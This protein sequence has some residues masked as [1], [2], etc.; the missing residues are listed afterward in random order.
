MAQLLEHEP[1]RRIANATV[2]TRRLEAILDEALPLADT[3]AGEG[4][5]AGVAA[6]AREPASADA[7]PALGPTQAMSAAEWIPPSLGRGPSPAGVPAELPATKDARP[8][9]PRSQ[10]APVDQLRGA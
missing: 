4:G 5:A 9:A 3:L 2:L 7:P 8:V 10:P 6:P 1:A